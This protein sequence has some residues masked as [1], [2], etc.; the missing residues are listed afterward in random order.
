MLAG[1]EHSCAMFFE[2]DIP[3]SCQA[4]IMQMQKIWSCK[5]FTLYNAQQGGLDVADTRG[6]VWDSGFG[7]TQHWKL[8]T[9]VKQ[10]KEEYT[11]DGRTPQ[12]LRP[13][14]WHGQAPKHVKG[15][16]NIAQKN[17]FKPS[18]L[19]TYLLARPSSRACRGEGSKE[20]KK[21]V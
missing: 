6:G 7:T 3:L 20:Q 4:R 15:E 5:C 16:G 11:D 2:K 14:D 9:S 18:C 10:L 12:V 13:L 17:T 8:I 19:T 1:A 21:H